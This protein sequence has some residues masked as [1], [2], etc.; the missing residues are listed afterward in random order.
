MPGSGIFLPCGF[1]LILFGK[2]YG[3]MHLS[4]KTEAF[5]LN[6]INIYSIEVALSSASVR[7]K[8][9][10]KRY[11]FLLLKDFSHPFKIPKWQWNR[12]FRAKK[13]PEPLLR[14]KN[15]KS[16]NL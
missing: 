2:I 14:G 10:R 12:K 9:F 8:R 6:Q 15:Q 4:R 13:T 1:V 5:Q 3:S 7:L 16:T 11:S